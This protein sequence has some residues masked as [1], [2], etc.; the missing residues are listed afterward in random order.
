MKSKI[1]TLKP[2]ELLDSFMTAGPKRNDVFKQGHELFYISRLEDLTELSKTPVPP[3][4][5]FAH[6]LF[7][8]QKG[9]L[10][11]KIGSYSIELHPNECA[12]IPAGQVFSYSIDDENKSENAQGFICGFHDDFLLGQIGSRD[13]LKSFEF[14]TVWGNPIIQLKK[15][16]AIFLSNSLGRVLAEYKLRGLQNKLVIQAH[17]I[18]LLCD[19]NIE[20]VP[21]S[22]HS[23]KRAVEITNRFKEYL[24][25]KINSTHKVSDYADMLHISP[26]HLNKSVKLITNKTPS[27]WIRVTLINEAKVLIFQTDLSI[28]Q[29]AFELGIDDPSYFTRIFKKHEGVTPAAYRK[30]IEMS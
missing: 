1:K 7:F 3:V 21:L 22:D 8:L 17:L 19:L 28:Q 24:Q 11:M 13:L 23:N 29:I 20:Y 18:A 6:T 10:V 27:E 30:M 9:L 25:E 5:A 15:E 16:S 4:K 14:L 12:L 2:A 26:N